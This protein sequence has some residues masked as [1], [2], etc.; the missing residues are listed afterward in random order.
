MKSNGYTKYYLPGS[1]FGPYSFIDISGGREEKGDDGRS[2]RNLAEVA[3]ALKIVSN[4]Y[5][6][7]I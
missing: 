7:K 1:M 6:G 3:V 5:R 4:L 2:I